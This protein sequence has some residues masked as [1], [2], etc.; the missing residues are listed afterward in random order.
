[1]MMLQK[2]RLLSLLQ[3]S[4]R[5]SLNHKPI[6]NRLVAGAVFYVLKSVFP[7]VILKG[8]S[9]EGS[10][11]GDRLDPSASPRLQDDKTYC[12]Y[13]TAQP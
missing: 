2:L 8:F 12:A 3:Y 6:K 1:M 13:L 10:Q 7:N 11:D 4:Q 9:P 5:L